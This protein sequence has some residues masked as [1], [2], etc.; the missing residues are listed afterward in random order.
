MRN[1]YILAATSVLFVLASCN[2]TLKI[3][4]VSFEV[5]TALTSYK[6]GDTVNFMFKGQPDM[7]T[8]YSGE[9]GHNYENRDRTIAKGAPQMQFT[10]YSQYGTQQNTL[11][12]LVSTDF[13]GIYDS[14]DIYKATWTDITNKA[15]LSTGG[16]DEPSGIIDLSPYVSDNKPI[17]V[18]YKYTGES[19]STQKTW[20]I[21]DFQINLLQDDGSESS[22]A[23][24]VSAG[25]KAVNIKNAQ[26]VWSISA[27]QLKIA[28]GGGGT[29]D[30]EDWLITSPLNT[31][32]VLP[33]VGVAIKDITMAMPGYSYVYTNAG[34]FKPVFVAVNATADGVKSTEKQ[35]SITVAP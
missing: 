17:Y 13:D 8:F 24:I 27:S 14:A 22:I 29:D 35:L 33:D 11:L 30:N 7:I 12:L 2:K 31:N 19:S 4:P 16:P 9:P 20:T 3:D 28:G 26:K 23:D 15:T 10:S 34:S 25:W 21:K 32:K 18:A 6:V 1:L 5:T